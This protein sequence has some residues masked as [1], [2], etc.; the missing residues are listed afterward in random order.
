MHVQRSESHLQELL[1]P[2]TCGSWGLN[3]SG[4][5]WQQAPAPS[6]PSHQPLYGKSF[7]HAHTHLQV[8]VIWYQITAR[9]SL[10]E[11]EHVSYIDC[12]PSQ[13]LTVCMHLCVCIM[14]QNA[15]VK[16]ASGLQNFG[17]ELLTIFKQTNKQNPKQNNKN[18][19]LHVCS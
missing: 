5:A 7:G 2:S 9:L 1:P 15:Q 16:N 17:Q 4:Q 18:S 6:E 8:L 12:T 3:S 19:I 11:R 10:G 13:H 14:S